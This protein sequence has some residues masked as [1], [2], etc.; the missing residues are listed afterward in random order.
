MRIRLISDA[1]VDM[2]ADYGESFIDD[3]ASANKQ[4]NA[5]VLAIAGDVMECGNRALAIEVFEKICGTHKNVVYVPGNHEYYDTS[6]F[7]VEDL[8]CD[9]QNRCSNLFVLDGCSVM[10]DDQKFIGG[11]LWFPDDLASS[12]RRML[13]DFSCIRS[14]VPW[15]FEQHQKHARCLLKETT[16]DSIVLTHHMPSPICTPARFALS[17]INKYFVA[18]VGEEIMQTKQPKMWLFGHTHDACD[19]MF[20]QT[21]MI[22]NPHGY[23][24]ERFSKAEY[25]FNCVFDI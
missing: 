20:D 12:H 1:H 22:C 16:K 3:L 19:K 18:N 2:H 14:F 25:D 10:V 17:P 9:I 7:E 23:L 15:V 5:D 6:P 8:L 4:N 13:A 21:R 11:T 24:S